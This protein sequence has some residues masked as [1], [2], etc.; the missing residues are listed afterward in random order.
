VS[1]R[2]VDRLINRYTNP[3]EKVYDP[4]SGL[5]TTPVRAVKLGRYGAGSE[6]NTGY[7]ADQ[8]YYCQLMEREVSMPTLFDMD[9]MD[10]E[11]AS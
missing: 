3:G 6:L 10:E 5:G 1:S 4:F 11:N 7:F 2:H 8:V 9:L